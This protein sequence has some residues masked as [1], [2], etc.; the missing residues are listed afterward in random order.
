MAQATKVF[1]YKDGAGDQITVHQ[2]KAGFSIQTSV[3]DPTGDSMT[4]VTIPSDVADDMSAALRG[5]GTLPDGK[6]DLDRL[7]AE[8]DALTEEREDTK[9][10]HDDSTLG[11]GAKN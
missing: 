11:I 6:A 4:F 2:H 5:L 9:P 7:R 8:A 10:V 1:E 3:I